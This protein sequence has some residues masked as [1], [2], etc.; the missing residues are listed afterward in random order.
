M[1]ITK[2][3]LQNF[4]SYR[5][6][7]VDLRHFNV[8]VG[9]NASGKS[10]FISALQ[11][12]RDIERHGLE[13]A[14]A[15]QGGVEYLVNLNAP[16]GK[17]RIEIILHENDKPSHVEHLMFVSSSD[18]ILILNRKITY[19][20]EITPKRNQTYSFYE[21]IKM[22]SQVNATDERQIPINGKKGY[23]IEEGSNKNGKRELKSN[24]RE[25]HGLFSFSDD[26][27]V[28]GEPVPFFTH[29]DTFLPI[30]NPFFPNWSIYNFA[31]IKSHL[32]SSIKSKAQLEENA[33]NIAMVIKR[34]LENEGQKKRFVNIIKS[35]LP[36]VEDVSAERNDFEQSVMFGFKEKYFDHPI[37]GSLLSD[38]SINL[39][40]L[41]LALFFEKGDVNIFEEPDASLHPA[42]MER[43]AGLFRDAARQKQIIITTHNPELIKHLALEDLLLLNRNDEGYSNVIR[44]AEKQMVKTFLENDMGLDE[45]FVQN[46]L[47]Y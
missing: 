19:N 28:H 38:G 3:R 2:I 18:A 31:N 10:N 47:A 34:L 36:H 8:L 26:R 15:L 41:V 43:L 6:V 25:L 12:L 11:F 24:I 9:P 33:S 21:K 1:H 46:L 13:N 39:T 27:A 40:A 4:K 42:L 14:I 32:P 23:F 17:L 37:A 44:P 22:T 16:N 29:K 7:E 45:L 30:S 35:V 5:D 20:L